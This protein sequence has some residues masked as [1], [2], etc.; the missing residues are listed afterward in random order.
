MEKLKI[1]FA[2]TSNFSEKH[3]SALINCPLCNIKAVI[4]QPDRPFGRGQKII[5]SPVKKISIKNKIPVLQPL[6]LDNKEFQKIILNFSAELMI[7]V[8]YGHIIPQKILSLFPKGCIN[9]HAS[10]L[11]RWRGASPIQSAILSG[12]K[13]T[14][15]SI[16]KMNDKVDAGNIIISKKCII[17]ST[18]TSETLSLK[19]IKIGTKILIKALFQ[20]HNNIVIETKQDEKY[21]TFSKK[22]LKI[23]ALLNWKKNADFLERLIRAFNPWPIC[24]FLI[25]NTPIKVW[26]AKVINNTTIKN[27]KIGQIISIDND[28]IQIATKEKILNI[29]KI[30]IPG[31][32]ISNINIKTLFK[33]Y[34]LTIG[35]ILI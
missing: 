2:G 10:L 9:V 4:T 24:Y 12:D 16:I 5:F 21:T 28:G 18:E 3:L 19:L 8:S 6:T 13:K 14:G 17:S 34:N 7:V 22:I 31:K 30:Q 1:I 25:N 29:E 20:I 32:N 26:K 35:T 11:P 23:D 15:I 33:K 27:Y